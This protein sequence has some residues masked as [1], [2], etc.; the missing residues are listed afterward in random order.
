IPDAVFLNGATLHPDGRR[1]LVAESV[2][3]RVLAV[4]LE[5][6]GY[7]TW[8][9]DDRLKPESQGTPGANGVKLFGGRVHV[10]VTG[11]NLLLRA[12]VAADGGCGA[13]EVWAEHLRAD[14]FAFATDGSAYIATHP[15][16][17]VL[18]LGTDGSRATLAGPDEGAI[19]ATAV[20]FGREPGV[21]Y[22]TTNGGLWS[23][24]QGQVQPARLLRLEVGAAGQTL[25][26]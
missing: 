1:L 24:Y 12:P 7:A 6:S 16:N 15:A 23:P 13:A 8:L 2:T 4:D 17:S 10:S 14:D 9:A 22:A 21:L 18:R 26:G 11:R 3:G 20:A 25:L 5:R 19:G